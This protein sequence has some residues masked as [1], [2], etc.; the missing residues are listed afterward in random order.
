M[1]WCRWSGQSGE[2]WV[3]RGKFHQVIMKKLKNSFTIIVKSGRK[4]FKQRSYLI[5]FV[6]GNGPFTGMLVN[7]WQPALQYLKKRK[8][9]EK[10]KILICG[11]CCF[12]WCKFSHCGWFLAPDTTITVCRCAQWALG[13]SEKSAAAHSG[14]FLAS[15]WKGWERRLEEGR[16]VWDWWNDSSFDIIDH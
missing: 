11:V 2:R 13:N 5:R 10:R 1:V 3:W 12:S 4:C 9:K 8:E 7:D 14:I 15:H 16:S 6:L